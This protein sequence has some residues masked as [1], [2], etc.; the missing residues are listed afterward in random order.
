MK[1][2]LVATLAASFGFAAV[3]LMADE[4]SAQ[5]DP[6][7]I[8]AGQKPYIMILMDTSASMEWTDKGDEQYPRAVQAGT[9][10]NIDADCSGGYDLC[11]ANRCM[12]DS[13]W[14]SESDI[15]ES[16]DP[17]DYG[18][19]TDEPVR[20]GSCYMWEPKC[21]DY[22]RPAWYPTD[23]WTE[24][25]E[26]GTDMYGRLTDMRDDLS[27]RMRDASQPRHV[28]LKEVLTGDML[29]RKSTEPDRTVES[30]DAEIDAPG[31]WIV[32]RQRGASASQI[33]VCK[34][35][36]KFEELPDHIE[37]RP[38]F[39]EVFEDQKRNGL[40]DLMATNAIFSIAMFDGYKQK[41]S[42]KDDL[43]DDYD[44]DFNGVVE[45]DG[46]D[47]KN[48]NLGVYNIL[49]P[50]R[51]DIST[52]M[53]GQVS[54][55]MQTALVDAGY[56]HKGGG[57]HKLEADDDVSDDLSFLDL[58]F[59]DDL[60]DYLDD[61]ELGRQPMA[62]A[63]PLAAAMHD[64]QHFFAEDYG[65][66]DDDEVYD[67]FLSCRPKQVIMLTDG[68]P[69]P[70]AP[71][72]VDLDENSL[73]SA[74]GFDPDLYP[75]TYTEKA[76]QRFV[77]SHDAT[78]KFKDF[79]YMIDPSGSTSDL[80]H[81]YNPR[82]HV[83]ALNIDTSSDQVVQK[84]A[85]MA[86]AGETCAGDF[87][88]DQFKPASTGDGS[89]SDGD[90]DPTTNCL[91]PRQKA[92]GYSGYIP[93]NAGPGATGVDCDY[94]ALILENNDRQSLT[95][96]L[97]QLFN[98]ILNT[99]GT[100]SRTTPAFVSN[101]DDTVTD[102]AAGGQYRFFSGVRI[103]PTNPYWKGLM[104]REAQY[105][106]TADG[107]AGELVTDNNLAIHEQI[108][109]LGADPDKPEDGDKRRIF[110]SFTSPDSYDYTNAL[111][112]AV[113]GTT[114]FPFWRK[115]LVDAGDDEFGD[116]SSYLSGTPSHI[117]GRV[118][119]E[120]ATLIPAWGSVSGASDEE[121]A[122]QS[123]F[124]VSNQEDFLDLIH[125][126][127][128]RTELQVDRLLGGILNGS[129]VAAEPPRLDIPV[130]SY[131]EYRARYSD[132]LSVTYVPTIDGLLH[133]V[134]S[135]DVLE[136][137]GTDIKVMART[138]R[139]S[140]D[141]SG[142]SKSSGEDVIHEQREAWAYIPEMLHREYVNYQGQ[143]SYLMD[144]TPVVKDMRLCNRFDDM[145]QNKQAC[146]GIDADGT[147]VVPNAEQWRTVLVQG[148]GLAG[149]GYFALDVTRPGGPHQN[150]VEFPDPI[151]LWEFNPNWEM[152]QI[153][154]TPDG[155]REELYY[156]RSDDLLSGG[157]IDSDG[158]DACSFNESDDNYFW[159][160][161]FLGTSVG[162]AALGTVIVRSELSSD[163]A[164]NI[165]RPVAVLSGGDA[166]PHG[167]PCDR[168][169]RSGRAIYVVDMQT[170]TMLRRF[171]DYKDPDDG[172]Y[173]QFP[174]PVTGSPALHNAFPGSLVTRGFVGDAE[175][176]LFRIDMSGSDP[177]DWELSLFFDPAENET[178]LD[179]DGP[180]GPAAFKPAIALGTDATDRNL[181]IFYGLG[182]PG[183]T[184]PAGDTQMV[185]ALEEEFDTFAFNQKPTVTGNLLW[186]ANLGSDG[187]NGPV[188]R[189]KLTGQPV[190]FNNAVY[191]TTY[192][193]PGE[194]VCLAGRSRIWGLKFEGEVDTAGDLT[195]N[196]EGVWDPTDG[197]F[198]ST[199]VT[200]GP[201]SPAEWF[202]PEQELLIRGLAVTLGPSCS[203]NVDG[204]S[205]GFNE[206][207]DRKP[208]L[209]AQTGGGSGTGDNLEK[210]S[211]GGNDSL[212]RIE[213]SLQ[214]PDSEN[215]PLSWK[216]IRN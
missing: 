135:G 132:R 126:I 81:R 61:Y 118:P 87:L 189:E 60:D 184:T 54:S 28:T 108:E 203:T 102:F 66:D 153:E 78:D 37:P 121:D 76:I 156:P 92:Y 23:E 101:L 111:P 26:S 18:D 40:M 30:L 161:P 3:S 200:F 213:K 127:R 119:F 147:T 86:E 73:N 210:S 120:V 7:S 31:C 55:F 196:I 29:L 183:D 103:D 191:F 4:A 44:D 157:D 212:S 63:T 57:E 88:G 186:N 179:A 75:Y 110:T 13:M 53:L 167:T 39:Q 46:K 140:A 154:A 11:I 202:S 15:V 99:A 105:C 36:G 33:E 97:A 79:G 163:T 198:D 172:K 124:G 201:G 190:V 160:Q 35:E 20:Y 100:S 24:E 34:D 137:D 169:K 133:A 182:E 16:G 91:D 70:E 117:D 152:G 8:G 173:K 48:Y 84:L 95:T 96:A 162:E 143:Q 27:T 205:G 1:Q 155:L 67:E 151:P 129:P 115:L 12:S 56:M 68:Y 72:G 130:D 45:D 197:E 193:V 74:F 22:E 139:S 122:T 104:F 187:S 71:G 176:R 171:V 98:S 178:A 89:C 107:A 114:R 109:R 42:W 77:K 215:I 62:K 208:T 164:P 188:L 83:V 166:G 25:Y 123:Y 90:N 50:E 199:G 113:D 131:R 43:D 9:S 159:G 177:A 141:G 49:T 58:S 112:I 142:W 214:P 2:W 175:G 158:D 216:V 180:F 93:P 32:P 5:Q 21:S 170:G 128:G 80:A 185:I 138:A 144:G 59:S 146:S 64:I 145:N 10:C 136:N 125:D 94:P 116:G 47:D 209:I 106:D 14:T 194:D 17:D 168:S 207:S 192:A 174:A 69:E 206:S 211:G 41:Q 52:S 6:T 134:Y 82:V 195:G 65:S 181:L 85:A 204:S 165:R 51:L 19:V 148:L 38:H 149:S 150:D